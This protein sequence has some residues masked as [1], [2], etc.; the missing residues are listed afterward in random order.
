MG[1]PAH[2]PE[3]H[4]LPPHLEKEVL[5]R[6]GD[7]LRVGALRVNGELIKWDTDTCS[8]KQLASFC[9]NLG[10]RLERV[11][12]EM[13][14][15]PELRRVA[16]WLCK[17]LS[18]NYVLIEVLLMVRQRT[19]VFCTVETREEHGSA[20]VEYGL[21]VLRGEFGTKLRAG[22]QWRTQDN[23]V[24]RD[25]A[26]AE[27]KIKGTLSLLSTEFG[28]PPDP[29][30]IPQYRLDISLRR[31]HAAQL[32]SRLTCGGRAAFFSGWPGVFTKALSQSISGASVIV[33]PMSCG[34]SGTIIEVAHGCSIEHRI[35]GDYN[36]NHR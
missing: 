26:T 4:A 18:I 23:I 24:Y 32:V 8:E 12:P 15:K 29:Q 1:V 19:G 2:A 16:Y 11:L 30:C 20:L 21:E 3:T 28:L 6:Y 14:G 34:G 35:R 36:P 7:I 5:Q 31:S 10:A 17:S 22:L 9:V 33:W 25:P 13:A 27:K